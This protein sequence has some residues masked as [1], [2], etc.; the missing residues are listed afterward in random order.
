M[1]GGLILTGGASSRMGRD[2]AALEIGGIRAIDR[3]AALAKAAGAAGVS[4]V[5]GR[6]W[7]YP[8]VVDATAF[9]GPVG[10]VTAGAAFLEEQGCQTILAFAVDA[11]TL[12]I[13][14]LRPLLSVR[15]GAAFEGFPLPFIAPLVRRPDA[16]AGW[17][18]ARLLDAWGVLRLPMPAGAGERL[19]GANTPAEFEALRQAAADAD[20]RAR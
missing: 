19:K 10:G 11:P 16:E 17:P 8:H 14:D 9:G 13:D 12:T 18:L 4:T 7:G 1:L 6:D 5:G 15:A 2:K 20:S 3:L